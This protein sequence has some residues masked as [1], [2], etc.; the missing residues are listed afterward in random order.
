ML[1]IAAATLAACGGDGSGGSVSVPNVVGDTQ[2]AAGTAITGA[3][4]TVGTVT[5]QSSSTVA[6]GDVILEDP[7][8]GTNVGSGTAV[9]LF[10]SSGPATPVVISGT[11]A[12]GTALTGTVSVYDSSASTQPRSSGGT[13]GTAGQYSV[14]VT[15]F[16]APFLIQATGQ[17]GGQGPTVTL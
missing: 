1:L 13:I 8:A 10:V 2:A 14:T 9:A 15:G 4:L 7:A 16:T 3:G 11:V 17:V 6:S 5:T 12:S